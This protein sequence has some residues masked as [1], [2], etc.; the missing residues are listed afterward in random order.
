MMPSYRELR[1]F[2]VEAQFGTFIDEIVDAPGDAGVLIF[3]HREAEP[4]WNTLFVDDPAAAQAVW[5]VIARCFAERGRRPDDRAQVVRVGD[6]VEGHQQPGAGLVVDRIGD[7]ITRIRVLVAGQLQRHALV[8]GSAGEPVEFG[9][10][11]LQQRD[12]ML[13]R[14]AEDLIEPVVALG[15]FGH[16]GGLDW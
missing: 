7:Q 6:P 12:R 9:A 13:G 16:V 5:P 2:H 15:P 14:V 1:R 8:H 3:S 10:G 4:M 11:G